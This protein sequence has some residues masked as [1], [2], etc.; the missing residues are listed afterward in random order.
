MLQDA[1]YGD[2][3]HTLPQACALLDIRLRVVDANP[4]Y[5]ALLGRSLDQVR[6][7]FLRDVLPSA[8]PDAESGWLAE[9]F[10]SCERALA[11][12]VSDSSSRGGFSHTPILDRHGRM[13]MLLQCLDGSVLPSAKAL[14]GI[15]HELNNLLQVIGGNLQLLAR[16]L[17]DDESARRRLSQ[18]SAAVD[19]AAELVREVR[20]KRVAAPVAVRLPPSSDGAVSSGASLR[21]L[22]VE[23][24]ST[25]RLLMGEVMVELGH[26]VCLSESAED[27]L[28]LLVTQ[29]FDVLLTDIGLA[30]MSGLDLVREVRRQGRGLAVVIAS[31]SVVD[32]EREGLA[33]V[34]TMIKPY[35][36]HQVRTLLDSIRGEF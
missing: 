21:V 26:Q 1:R 14:S 33:G 32:I 16:S 12:T 29:P 18:M 15:A 31:G 13:E 11:L 28:Q 9:L 36:I 24:D 4:A 23:D 34:R 27:A 19:S 3:F 2:V 6:G 7:C 5:L 22:L 35:D 25:L 10:T 30:G 20:Q 17:P 8:F